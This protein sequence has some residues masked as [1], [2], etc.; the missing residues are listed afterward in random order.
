MFGRGIVQQIQ[1][2]EHERMTQLLFSLLLDQPRLHRVV[3]IIHQSI[4]NMIPQGNKPVWAGLCSLG[5][6]G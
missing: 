6:D 4:M 2:E 3:L 5:G 1:E